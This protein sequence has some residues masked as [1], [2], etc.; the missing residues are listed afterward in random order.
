[1]LKDYSKDFKALLL[2]NSVKEFVH[3]WFDDSYLSKMSQFHFYLLHCLK[4]KVTN[5]LWLMICLLNYEN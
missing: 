4:I 5:L 2:P 3:I 1:M